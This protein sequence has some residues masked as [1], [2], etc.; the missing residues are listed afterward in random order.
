MKRAFYPCFFPLCLLAALASGCKP[1]AAEPPD[2]NFVNLYAN[3]RLVTMAFEHDADRSGMARRAILAEHRMTGEDFS[4][5]LEALMAA[6]DQWRAFEEQVV[7]RTET[8][9]QAHKGDP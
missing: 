9:Q 7:K 6:P 8:L 5:R 4:R 1:K 2:A 3:L